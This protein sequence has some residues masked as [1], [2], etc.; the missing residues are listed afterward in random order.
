MDLPHAAAAAHA[1]ELKRLY[2]DP[3]AQGRGVGEALLRTALD[4]AAAQRAP[5]MY[6]GV[7]CENVG[8]QRLYA[9]H[10]FAKVG[11]YE[12]PVGRHRDREFILRRALG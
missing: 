4:W 1:V 2:V 12:F 10:G 6:L 3:P 8:A 11:E 9:R 5:E 7:Y